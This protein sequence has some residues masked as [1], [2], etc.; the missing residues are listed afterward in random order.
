[1]KMMMKR[2]SSG[3]K[4][5]FLPTSSVNRIECIRP[6]SLS[7]TMEL[8]ASRPLLASLARFQNVALYGMYQVPAWSWSSSSS[9]SSSHVDIFISRF[10]T[11]AIYVVTKMLNAPA[12]APSPKVLPFA[13]RRRV[14]AS[15]CTSGMT[16]SRFA[17]QGKVLVF[18]L[19]VAIY[20]LLWHNWHMLLIY[21]C[22]LT[23][24]KCF[25]F[26]WCDM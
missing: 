2:S 26:H 5:R 9:S 13:A 1:M 14:V 11:K 18:H 22:V 17:K 21:L 15:R 19:F 10:F 6:D 7:Q 23:R 12:T 25:T 24:C 8:A 20:E 3:C 16:T 4:N